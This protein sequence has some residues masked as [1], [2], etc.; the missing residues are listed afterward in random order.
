MSHVT[1]RPELPECCCMAATCRSQRTVLR[2]MK[3]GALS[4][5]VAQQHQHIATASITSIYHCSMGCRRPYPHLSIHWLD[6]IIR[7]LCICTLFYDLGQ[8]VHGPSNSGRWKE[9][10]LVGGRMMPH[11]FLFLC[12]FSAITLERHFLYDTYN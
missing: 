7:L 3:R 4:E 10:D 6:F 1:R 2:K 11:L 5:R 8:K 9:G 12:T